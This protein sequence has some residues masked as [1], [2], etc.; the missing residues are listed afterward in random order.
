MNIKKIATLILVVMTLMSVTVFAAEDKPTS[1][2]Y[3]SPVYGYSIACPKRP[4]VVLASEFFDDDT[5]KGEVLIFENVEYEVKRGW[6]VLLDAFNSDVVPNFNTDPKEKIDEYLEA[7]QVQ[8]YEGI[9]LVDITKD[10]KGALAI[11]AK[12]IAIDEDG[13]GEPD[14]VAVSDHQEAIAFFRTPDGKC[15]SVWLMGT[16]D[17]NDA[18]MRNFRKALMTFKIN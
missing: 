17:L 8:G 18:A 5:K 7:L 10:N 13:D 12:E 6:I 2:I 3:T 15:V 11:T 4:N 1:Y 14:G 16:D 9:A